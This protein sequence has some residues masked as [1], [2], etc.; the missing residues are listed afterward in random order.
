MYFGTIEYV[1][2]L[3]KAGE[4]CK[5]RA[6]WE[7]CY[8]ME[9]Q[10]KNIDYAMSWGVDEKTM[11]DWSSEFYAAINDEIINS[12]YKKIQHAKAL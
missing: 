4:R 8:D 3:I 5:A 7:Y 12:K 6:F 1:R 11:L 2:K 10:S 9:F